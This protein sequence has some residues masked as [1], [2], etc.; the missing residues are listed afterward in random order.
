MKFV[1]LSVLGLNEKSEQKA[2]S[3]E[4]LYQEEMGLQIGQG[5]LNLF[6]GL[7]KACLAIF[8]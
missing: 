3:A 1:K 2:D 4:V 8:L 6:E 5:R 7:I